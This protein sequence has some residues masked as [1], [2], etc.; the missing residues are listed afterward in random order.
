[1]CTAVVRLEPDAAWPILLGFVRDE[2]RSR[3]THAPDHW[4]PEQPTVLG[5]RDERAGGTWLAVDLGSRDIAFVQNQI[6]PHVSFPDASASPSRGRLPL[7]AL[8]DGDF[9]VASLD[10]LDTY[11]P[12]HLVHVRAGDSPTATWWQWSGASLE[13]L[14]LQPGIH[15][16]ASRGLDLPGER[17]RRATHLERFANAATPD[18][19]PALDPRGA[20][21]EWIDLLDGRDAQPGDL[22]GI[23]L[24]S[25]PERP[26]FG[27]VGATLVGIA[28]DGR[29]RYDVND[30]T[31]VSPDAW[32]QVR[33]ASAS[34]S[35]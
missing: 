11:Q 12:F 22:G 6:G 7:A 5:A 8:A 13:R 1:M 32:S 14:E 4:W 2:E 15:L 9:D 26:A 24:H 34:M 27:T 17:E 23:V 21:G 19:D 29:V 10:A 25:V 30:T 35:A 31:S 18:P 20:W 16:V 3:T 28:A 33:A